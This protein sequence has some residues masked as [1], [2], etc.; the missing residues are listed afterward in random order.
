MWQ[1]RD[2]GYGRRRE[3]EVRVPLRYSPYLYGKTSGTPSD[4]AQAVGKRKKMP[5]HCSGYKIEMVPSFALPGEVAN[6]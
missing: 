3:S 5:H 4:V 6:T 1:W 2:W